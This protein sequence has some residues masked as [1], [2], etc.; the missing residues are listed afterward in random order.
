MALR[1]SGIARSSAARSLKT[2]MIAV[3]SGAGHL[4]FLLLNASGNAVTGSDRAFHT[5][6]GIILLGKHPGDIDAMSF[7]MQG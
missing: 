1:D 4:V 7:N 5:S 3:T 6:L 2:G